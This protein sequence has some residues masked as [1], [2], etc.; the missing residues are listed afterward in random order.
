MLAL[1]SLLSQQTIIYGPR[2]ISAFQINDIG[3]QDATMPA[4]AWEHVGHSFSVCLSWKL[5]LEL[6]IKELVE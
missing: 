5:N 3:R 1:G 4:S 6:N 2:L